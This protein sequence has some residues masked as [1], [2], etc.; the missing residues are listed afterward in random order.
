MTFEEIYVGQRVKVNYAKE[1]SQSYRQPPINGRVVKKYPHS[2]NIDI[3]IDATNHWW[4]GNIRRYY[5]WRL[6]NNDPPL[7]RLARALDA[8]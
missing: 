6:D 8:D 3:A 5:C 4:H 2:H 7:V 1:G